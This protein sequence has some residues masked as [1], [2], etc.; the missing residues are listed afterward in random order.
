MFPFD[1]VIISE[2]CP[3]HTGYQG[4]YKVDPL[5]SRALADL[6]DILDRFFE[7]ILVIDG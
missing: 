7:L 4:S 3:N 2:R 6:K 1:D 5:N